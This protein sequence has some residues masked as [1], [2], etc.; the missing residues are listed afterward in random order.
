MDTTGYRSYHGNQNLV[1][2][3][4]SP[5]RGTQF[6]HSWMPPVA[7]RRDRASTATF[8]RT[9]TL[10]VDHLIMAQVNRLARIPFKT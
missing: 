3:L 6:F 7:L 9:L 5:V 8:V 2:E 1:R 4:R 10:D